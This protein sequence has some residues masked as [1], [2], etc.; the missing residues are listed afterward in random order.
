MTVK[1]LLLAHAG[2]RVIVLTGAAA[3][4]AI[5]AVRAEPLIGS[6]SL[7]TSLDPATFRLTL[8]GTL[9]GRPSLWGD[10]DL[11]VLAIGRTEDDAREV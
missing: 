7:K 9:N 3:A 8:H 5:A 11:D 1:D 2:R 10:H 4:D 6:Y